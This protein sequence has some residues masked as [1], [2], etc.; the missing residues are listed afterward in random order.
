MG[1]GPGPARPDLR[2]ATAAR[3]RRAG[4]QLDHADRNPLPATAARPATWPPPTATPPPATTGTETPCPGGAPT[5]NFAISAVDIVSGRA[6]VAYVP[7]A[8]A[9]AVRSGN[10]PV[11]PL[12]MHV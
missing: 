7:T 9:G 3:Q 5:R 6:K 2:P 8:D 1:A 11:E 4:R 12:V 10:K